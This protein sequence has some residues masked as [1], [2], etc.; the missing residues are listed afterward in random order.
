MFGIYYYSIICYV[1]FIFCLI[2]LSFVD[3]EEEEREFSI[4]N[5]I[6]KLMFNGYFE[7]IILNSII[8]V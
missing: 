2:L 8:R 7:Y 1:F 6:S 3:I 5:F 4:I